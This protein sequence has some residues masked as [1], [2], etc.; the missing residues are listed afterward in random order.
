MIMT[1]EVNRHSNNSDNDNDINIPD[2]PMVFFDIPGGAELC[3]VVV[4][5]AL[6]GHAFDLYA[7]T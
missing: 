1:I 6:I 5:P 7:I 4:Y 3:K 2:P